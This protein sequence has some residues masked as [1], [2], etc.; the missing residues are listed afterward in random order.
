MAK[1]IFTGVFFRGSGPGGVRSYELR[2]DAEG[3]RYATTRAGYDP[4]AYLGW[5]MQNQGPGG[6]PRVQA[7]GNALGIPS[8]EVWESFR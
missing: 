7:I 2:A 3:A 8:H 6:W 1:K 4:A 5:V